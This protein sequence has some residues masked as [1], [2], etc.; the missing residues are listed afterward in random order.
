MFRFSGELAKEAAVALR[1]LHDL[2]SASRLLARLAAP[3]H[4]RVH[5]LCIDCLGELY[6]EESVDVDGG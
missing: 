4:E 3:E 5:W 2:S 6:A 1:R